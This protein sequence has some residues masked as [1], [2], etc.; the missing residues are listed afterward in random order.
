MDRGCKQG[1]TLV[2]I[3]TVVAIISVLSSISIASYQ[4]VRETVQLHGVV[5]DLRV[6]AAAYEL[7][8]FERGD[9]PGENEGLPD[10]APPVTAIE[11]YLD[12][13]K[14]MKA[15]P[16]GTYYDWDGK[17][18]YGYAAISIRSANSIPSKLLRLLDEKMDDG[19]ITT[20]NMLLTHNGT[21]LSYMLQ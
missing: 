4:K 13:E 18:A 20:G 10:P 11:S 6:F 3:M 21:R 8:S 15:K 1:F 16:F 17:D 14:F 12:G 19:D 9:Y 7:Y 2:E 5:N